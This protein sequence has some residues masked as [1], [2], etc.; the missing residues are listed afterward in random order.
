MYILP[1][2]PFKSIKYKIAQ[3]TAENRKQNCAEKR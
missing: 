3:T 2:F 1:T